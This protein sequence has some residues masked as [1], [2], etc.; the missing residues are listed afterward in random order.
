MSDGVAGR[1]PLEAWLRGFLANPGMELPRPPA[2]ALEI[3]NLSQRPKARIEDIAALLEREPLLAGR[4]LRLSNSAMYASTTPCVT[5]KQALV[6]MGLV[7][8]RDVVMEAAMQLTSIDAEGFNQTLESVRRHSAAVA[9]IS[10]FVARNTAIEAD[11]AFLMGLLH[12]VG[13]SFALVGVAQYQKLNGLPARLSAP[14]WRVAEEVH[15]SFSAQVL[16]SWGLPAHLGQV[17]GHHHGLMIDGRPHPQVAVLTVAEQIATDLGWG[18]TPVVEATREHC[19]LVLA[20]E[21]S[22]MEK[23]EQALEVLCLDLEHFERIRADVV[24]VLETLKA[25]FVAPAGSRSAA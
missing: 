24:R 11:N 20:F 8:V 25:Q 3:L 17:V 21:L 19:S 15:E 6:R 16:A 4:V 5:L 1:A 22:N 12:D 13:L 10:R 7:L 2:V 9:W 14:S 23:T 18:V